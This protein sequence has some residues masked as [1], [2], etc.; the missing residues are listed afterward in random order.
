MLSL[1][2]LVTALN[3]MGTDGFE[4]VEFTAPDP[5]PLAALFRTFGFYE[6]AK[7][8]RKKVSLWQQGDINFILNAESQGHGADFAAAH[9]PSICAMAFR[10]RDAAYAYRRALQLGAVGVPNQ[11]GPME[12]NIPG[13][14]P[15]ITAIGGAILYLVDRY[16]ANDPTGK[17]RL[18]H[19]RPY[20]AFTMIMTPPH[21]K[22]GSH[23]PFSAP[24]VCCVCHKDA[25]T[26][27]AFAAIFPTRRHHRL[28]N[29]TF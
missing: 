26:P 11:T 2:R 9:G 12:L 18:S 19:H 15:G 6:T 28:T 17:K 13:I 20:R 22:A 4:F 29:Y 3:P 21:P 23:G 5:K 24:H 27:Q 14:I 7:H 16:P 25:K 1:S 8:R 10:V